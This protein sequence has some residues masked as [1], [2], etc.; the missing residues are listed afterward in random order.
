MRPPRTLGVVLAALLVLAPVSVTA[1]GTTAIDHTGDEITLTAAE[2]QQIH[3]TTPFESGT[4]IGVRI[5]SVGDTHPFLVSKA[6]RVTENGSFDVAFDLSGLS[7][8]RGGPVEVEVRHNETTIHEI[9]GVLV[10]RNMPD[11]S[12]LTY[13]TPTEETTPAASKTPSTTTTS[14]SF[15]GLDVPGLGLGVGVVALVSVALLAR[16]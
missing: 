16:R 3:G 8:L 2:A 13:Q 5:K 4:V 14:A 1:D 7:P 9:G 10:T 11:D 6:V 12:T 15:S